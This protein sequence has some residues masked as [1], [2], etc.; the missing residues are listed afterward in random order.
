M[1]PREAGNTWSRPIEN[2][3]RTAVGQEWQGSIEDAA[4]RKLDGLQQ[5]GRDVGNV[6]TKRLVFRNAAIFCRVIVVS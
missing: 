5:P 4:C 2:I 1:R 3:I 6:V